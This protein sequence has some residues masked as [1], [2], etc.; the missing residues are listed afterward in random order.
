MLDD[1]IID[2]DLYNKL[3]PTGS[4]IPRLY[5]LPKVHKDGVPLRPILYVNNSP[6]HAIAKWLNG[7][8]DPIRKSLSIYSVKDT[9]EFIECIKN[10]NVKGKSM[11]SL[12]V[13]SL[14]TNVPLNETI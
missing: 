4:T 2:K 13:I 14:F 1:S 6:Y 5:G 9:F 10:I 11:L 12:D 3:R 7:I 8:L